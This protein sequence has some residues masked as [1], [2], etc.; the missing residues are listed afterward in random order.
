MKGTQ[1]NWPGAT[2]A[3]TPA[4][5]SGSKEALKQVKEAPKPPKEAPAP[6]L[7]GASKDQPQTTDPAKRLKNLKKRLREVEALEQ[8]I[9]SGELK[10]PDKDQLEKVKRK[11]DLEEQIADLEDELGL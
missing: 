8:K 3:V 4:T 5:T 1:I 2:A 7:G 11:Y 6:K 10:T 9:T